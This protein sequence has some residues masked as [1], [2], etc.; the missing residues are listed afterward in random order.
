MSAS[1]VITGCSA[2]GIG[3]A[4]AQEFHRRGLLVFATARNV[5]KINHLRIL[6]CEVVELDVTS[7][8]SILNAVAIVTR[9][10]GG[11]LDFLVN[12]AGQGELV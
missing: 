5:E 10:T 12:N 1:V 7:E 8:Q 3:D 4:L 2:G 9:V 11:K 6:G